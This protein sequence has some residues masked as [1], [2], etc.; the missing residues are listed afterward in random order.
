MFTIYKVT[1]E[2]DGP[3]VLKF[4]GYQKTKE[5]KTFYVE[6]KEN[7]EGFPYMREKIIS[8]EKVTVCQNK[9]EVKYYRNYKDEE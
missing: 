7:L 9:H 3:M 1:Y 2:I 5:L 4:G 8:I 6:S